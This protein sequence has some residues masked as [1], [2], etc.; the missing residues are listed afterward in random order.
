LLLSIRE[1]KHSLVNYSLKS[2]RAACLL[3]AVTQ[4]NL[5]GPKAVQD[6]QQYS[7]I[8][9]YNLIAGKK[10]MEMSEFSSA[11]N[12]FDNGITFLRKKHWQDEYEL[13]LELYNLAAKCALSIKEFSTM[14]TLCSSISVRSR[15]P[16]D[17]LDSSFLIMTAMSHTN[18]LQ[19]LDYALNM[20]MQLGVVLPSSSSRNDALNEIHQTQT[21]LNA[22]SDETILNYHI[23][24]DYKKIMAMKLLSKML[25]C[26][27]QCKP[28]L[29]PF[30][31]VKLVRLAIQHGLVSIGVIQ[32][33][34][35]FV[36]I[37][38]NDFGFLQSPMS[39]LGFA[40]FGGMI[41]EIGDL[42]GGYRF[43]KLSK[44]LLNKHQSHEIAGEVMWI[45]SDTL[46][47]IQP[48]QANPAH[49]IEGQKMAMAAGDIH[50]A[51]MNRLL[52]L[53]DLLW[54]G[55]K[56]SEYKEALSGAQKVSLIMYRIK[57]SNHPSM[58][59]Y[60]RD[61]FSHILLYT[62]L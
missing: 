35:L 47:Y 42:R 9:R 8:A 53:A 28:F 37:R 15:T 12:Y 1:F 19:S 3:S 22:I 20:L 26:V 33:C 45:T 56:L 23:S 6:K 59:Y 36:Y 16:E 5:G 34:H 52:Y 27:N 41:A 38:L 21:M 40:C 50:C 62:V 4:L 32:F 46:S 61:K 57:V 60:L 43:T 58:Q 54:T 14:T 29:A 17:A 7:T 30:V 2:G 24:T 10:S 51:C 11:F 55:A 13:S 31:T 25:T 44:A 49:R 48:L 18:L 39:T